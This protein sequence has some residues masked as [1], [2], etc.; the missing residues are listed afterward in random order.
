MALEI[1]IDFVEVEVTLRIRS[2]VR[3]ASLIYS[4]NNL[5]QYNVSA[6]RKHR[7]KRNLQSRSQC[8]INMRGLTP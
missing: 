6:L 4:R 1:L 7:L 3:K 5:I 8:S 2:R